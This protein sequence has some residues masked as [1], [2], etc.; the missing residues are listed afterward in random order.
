[1]GD[2]RTATCSC[3]LYEGCL[4]ERLRER[5]RERVVASTLVIAISVHS[6]DCLMVNTMS[7]NRSRQR[8]MPRQ[9]APVGYHMYSCPS[10][11]SL[12]VHNQR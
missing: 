8:S 6:I 2:L 1:M 3:D 10:W 4:G 5:L 11:F 7:S 9:L 12:Q